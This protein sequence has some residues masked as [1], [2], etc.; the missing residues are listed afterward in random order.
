MSPRQ[1]SSR[2]PMLVSFQ[3]PQTRSDILNLHQSRTLFALVVCS[4][5]QVPRLAG[6]LRYPSFR[7]RFMREGTQAADR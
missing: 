3:N 4:P 1:S 5:P 2:S 6:G 7:T